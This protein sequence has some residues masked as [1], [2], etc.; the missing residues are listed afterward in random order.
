MA[1]LYSEGIEPQACH[2]RSVLG[3]ILAVRIFSLIERNGSFTFSKTT[4]IIFKKFLKE[5]SWDQS[6]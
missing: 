6:N 3:T 2:Y 1:P 4:D 5:W